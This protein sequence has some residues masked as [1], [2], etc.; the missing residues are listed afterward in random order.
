MDT[1]TTNYFTKWVEAIPVRNATNS[2][3]MKFIEEN[4]LSRFGCPKRI[5]T[6]N[7][8]A[9]SSIKMIEFCQTY[10]ISLHHST[11]YYP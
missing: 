5:V 3:V 7:V 8:K 11:L 9:F 1:T 6:N 2:M 4:I 10:Q